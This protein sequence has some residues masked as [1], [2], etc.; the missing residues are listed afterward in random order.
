MAKRV[1]RF[2]ATRR[3][4]S[5][6][7]ADPLEKDMTVTVMVPVKYIWAVENRRGLVEKYTK[8]MEEG[9]VFDPI[10]LK[11]KTPGTGWIFSCRDGNHRVVSAKRAGIEE[12]LA[13]MR[14]S[15]YQVFLRRIGK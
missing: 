1:K 14:E 12:L 15:S 6:K 13:T 11:L 3:R 5:H 10:E 4:V 8:M 7:S 9:V 2:H